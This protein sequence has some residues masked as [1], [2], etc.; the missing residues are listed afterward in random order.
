MS[1]PCSSF[2]ITGVVI[3]ALNETLHRGK[4]REE[5]ARRAS[6]QARHH[7]QGAE[8][9]IAALIE[10]APAAIVAVDKDGT[11]VLVNALTERL[12]GYT[13]AEMVGK[14]VDML[15]PER[16]RREHPRYRGEFSGSPAMRQMG[17][18]RD[19]Y[20]LRKDGTE[21]PVEIGLNP[22]EVDGEILVLSSIVDIT[23]RKRMEAERE[24]LLAR[25]ESLITHAPIG[26]AVFDTSRRYLSLNA[27]A[28]PAGLSR[29]GFI[30]R[31]VREF[32]TWGAR[33]EA[34]LQRVLDTRAPVLDVEVSAETAA[35]PAEQRH[36]I[37]SNY[38]VL[39]RDGQVS[40][41]GM[42]SLDITER[43]RAENEHLRLLEREQQARA[44][45]DAANRAK[46]LFIA[47]AS[48]E[49]RT[50]LNALM[51]WTRMLR[52]RQIARARVPQAI[53]SIDRN[54][55]V[56]KTLVEDL[57]DMSRLTTGK[58]QVERR[59]LNIVA[60]AHEA[61][62]LIQPAADAE[63]VTIAVDVPSHPIP[64]EGDATRLRQ[65]FWNL[66][67]NAIKFTPQDGRVLVQIRVQESEIQIKVVDTGQG[68][69][70]DFLPHVFEPFSQATTAGEGL[71]LGLAIV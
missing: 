9:R 70:P 16:F 7:A 64:V 20:G 10:A 68:I 37:E 1:P 15:V 35:A 59:R 32:H 6:E 56:L 53:E 22:I 63:G 31:P 29:E 41:I 44:E 23:E 34:L 11:I 12:F 66:V 61:I 28:A 46:D 8:R 24:H 69:E 3:S 14:S 47:R 71:G 54:A 42:V 25:F 36:F 13:R 21:V 62:H 4:A 38:P 26:I 65:V 18:G 33:V 67:S 43:K 17:A 51:G 40:A 39:N 52:D 49:L 58:L 19:L 60:V 55:E 5:A 48:H 30:G 57:I 27:N 50:P 2:A 45:A